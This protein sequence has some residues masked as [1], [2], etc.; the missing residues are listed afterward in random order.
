MITTLLILHALLA[1]ALIGGITHQTLSAWRKPALP[2][3]LGRSPQRSQSRHRV[4]DN[5]LN[6]LPIS[7][8]S[9][10]QNRVRLGADFQGDDS[11]RVD[12][13]LV[14]EVVLTQHVDMRP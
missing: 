4:F 11:E 3:S 6:A 12:Q 10:P 14:G 7:E 9:F 8:F 1:V 2:Q 5:P 13:L